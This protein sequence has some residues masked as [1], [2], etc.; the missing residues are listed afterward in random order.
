MARP[1]ITHRWR[2]SQGMCHALRCAPSGRWGVAS[3][4]QQGPLD[5]A[6]S[7]S[8]RFLREGRDA[9]PGGG[10][11][12]AGSVAR[13]QLADRSSAEGPGLRRGRHS[14]TRSCHKQIG[15]GGPPDSR[16]LPQCFKSSSSLRGVLRAPIIRRATAWTSPSAGQCRSGSA[17]VS[18]HQTPRL[19]LLTPALRG[20]G[21]GCAFAKGLRGRRGVQTACR[22]LPVLTVDP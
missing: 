18:P 22:V 19:P 13:D 1:W 9:G 12:A 8:A 2:A 17:P 20:A 11:E 3:A 5:S 21:P 7:L 14:P 10:C 16:G 6:I 4:V 15:P